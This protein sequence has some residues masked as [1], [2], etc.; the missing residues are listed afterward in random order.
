MSFPRLTCVASAIALSLPLLT[1]GCGAPVA[2]VAASYGAD[3]VSLAETGKTTSDHFVSIVTKEDCALWRKFRNQDICRPRETDHDPY[4]VNY[5][6][7]FRQQGEGGT[8]YSPPPHAAVDAPATSWDAAAYKPSPQ[9]PA[10]AAAETAGIGAKPLPPLDAQPPAASPSEAAKPAAK[11]KPV[12]KPK[13]PKGTEEAKKPSPGQ[14]V[15]S[16]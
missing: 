4:H 10:P 14:V 2:I 12:H 7:P 1:G 8:E 6:E 5:D 11:H 16:R 3:G 15:S 9:Q 13:K